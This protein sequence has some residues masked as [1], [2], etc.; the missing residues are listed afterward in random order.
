LNV[1]V[2]VASKHGSTSEIARIIAGELRRMGVR[3]HVC[4]VAEVTDLSPYDGLILG[5]AVYMGRW[6]P[7]A[8]TFVEKH[9]ATLAE[10]PT[11]L[12]SSGPLGRNP[13]LPPGDPQHLAQVMDA[14]RAT[15]H[16]IFAGRLDPSV[17]GLGE[18]LIVRVVHAPAGDFRDWDTVVAWSREIGRELLR[19]GPPNPSIG[20]SVRSW[21][22]A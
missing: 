1:L 12:F 5:S 10:L 6:L 16:K 15:E 17:L 11:W 9:R 19:T 22:S 3:T 4:S 2:A 13:S 7:E 18:R 20:Q 14:T 8:I 21:T